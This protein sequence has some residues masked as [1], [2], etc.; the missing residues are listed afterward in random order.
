MTDTSN[1]PQGRGFWSTVRSVFWPSGPNA[2]FLKRFGGALFVGTAAMLMLCGSAVATGA[3][4]VALVH[5]INYVGQLVGL[6]II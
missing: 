4:A 5:A 6:T 1:A 2:D 3:V